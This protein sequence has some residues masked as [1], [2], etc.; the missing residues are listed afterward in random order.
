MAR[1]SK[2]VQEALSACPEGQREEI[3]QVLRHGLRP[4]AVLLDESVQSTDWTKQIGE[5]EPVEYK[6]LPRETRELLDTVGCTGADCRTL[7]QTLGL[8]KTE[9]THRGLR[10]INQLRSR[11]LL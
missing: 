1:F 5:E 7:G 6:T 8:N 11:G 4:E 2:A 3:V 10:A 9:L